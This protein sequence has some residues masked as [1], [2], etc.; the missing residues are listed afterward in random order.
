MKEVNFESKGAMPPQVDLRD[1]TVVALAGQYPDTFVLSPLPAV[2]NQ[3][4]VG[5]C[6]AHALSEI[7]EYFN[8]VETGKF[9]RL[10]TDFIYG[11]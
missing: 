6:V 10:S 2:K 11:M 7:L 3:S 8:Q 9:T 1:Y 5:S 4:A